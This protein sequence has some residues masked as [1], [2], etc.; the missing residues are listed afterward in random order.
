[1]VSTNTKSG[2]A[3]LLTVNEKSLEFYQ[4]IF[5]YL[6]NLKNRNYILVTEHIGQENKHYHIYVQYEN[7][8]RL[9]LAKLHGAHVE[10][11]FGSAQKNIDYCKCEDEK[12]K[13]L[14]VTAVLIEE[15]GEP[16]MN[17]RH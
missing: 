1:M 4:D 14:G 6:N 9:S 11:C 16:K 15:E 7:S 5:D 8:R 12:H 3:F 13:S 10:K 2:K 17:G